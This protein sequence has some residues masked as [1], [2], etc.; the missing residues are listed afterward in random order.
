M[1]PTVSRQ[2]RVSIALAVCA[3]L[4]Y[5]TTT[6]LSRLAYDAGTSPLFLTLFRY[7]LVAVIMIAVVGVL[8]KPWRLNVNL[9]LLAGCTLGL[10]MISIGHLGAVHYIPV[11]L[12]AIIFYTFP[13]QVLMYRLCVHRQSV[14]VIEFTAFA[15]AFI[16]LSIA[17]G[18]KFNIVDW[19]GLVLAFMGS[20]GAA[21]FL[22][23]YERFPKQIDE[24][25]NQCN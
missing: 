5:G 10:F 15:L 11:S 3:S 23:C 18:P 8:R 1:N 9:G 6:T 25:G 4:G 12:A 24:N 14:S 16:G 2:Q 21:L 20:L 19:R 22:L 7:A 13:L 17:L